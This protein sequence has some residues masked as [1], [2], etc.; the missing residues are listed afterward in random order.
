M[1]HLITDFTGYEPYR[2]RDILYF[3]QFSEFTNLFRN[4]DFSQIGN[5]DVWIVAVTIAVVAS[6][7]TLLSLEAVDKIDPVKRVSPTNRE[8]IAQGFGNMTSGLLGGM[9]M[10]AVIVRSS[11]NVNAGASTKMS[12]IYHG[13]WLLAA[14]FKKDTSSANLI[15]ISF[16][17]PCEPI[18]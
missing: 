3:C 13:F 18:S 7:E 5:K 11:A 16:L 8:L 17:S 6:I 4:P 10:T 2:A 9:P 15:S 14:L 12:A 1:Y